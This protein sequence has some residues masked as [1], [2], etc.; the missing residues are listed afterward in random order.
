MSMVL[1]VGANSQVVFMLELRERQR[2]EDN[3]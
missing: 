2:A 3:G 1:G